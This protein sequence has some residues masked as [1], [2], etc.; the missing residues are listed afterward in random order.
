MQRYLTKEDGCYVLLWD[1]R[2]QSVD[3]AIQ[4]II[5]NNNIYISVFRIQKGQVTKQ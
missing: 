2:M 4:V 1:V 5:L 3:Q